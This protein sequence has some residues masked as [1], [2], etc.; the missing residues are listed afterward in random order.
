[1]RYV[2]YKICSYCHKT[3]FRIYYSNKHRQESF[4]V[5][6]HS[7]RERWQLEFPNVISISVTIIKNALMQFVE[8]TM[9]HVHY[10]NCLYCLKTQIRIYCSNKHRQ[11]SFVVVFHP[12]KERRQLEFPNVISVLVT[13]IK[14]A[15]MQFVEITMRYVHY[16]NCYCC[17]KTQISI[18]YSNKHIQESFVVFFHSSK[19]KCQL[20]FLNVFSILITI[21]KTADVKVYWEYFLC[22]SWVSQ[23]C[24]HLWKYLTN[25]NLWSKFK[26]HILLLYQVILRLICWLG[27]ASSVC[28][29][30]CPGL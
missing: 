15:L 24:H 12:S 11:E 21:I 6:F 22:I 30:L 4:V 18:Y 19:E 27:T 29:S 25:L 10:Q 8:I 14:N 20:E 23:K 1:M 9:K 5:V 28:L 26:H 13:I 3:P 16:K 7:S 2:R 17:H